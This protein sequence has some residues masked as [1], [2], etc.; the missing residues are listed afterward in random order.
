MTSSDATSD[1]RQAPLF[2]YMHREHA[3]RL[4]REGVLRIGTLHE[5]RNVERHGTHVGDAEEGSKGAR[6]TVPHL[7]ARSSVDLPEFVR[8]RIKIGSGATVEMVNPTFIVS[9]D[10]PD[11]FIFSCSSSFDPDAMREMGY[12]ACV[13]VSNP[14][15]FLHAV[16]HSMRHRGNFEGLFSCVYTERFTQPGQTHPA[17]PA[18]LKAP[19]YAPQREQRAIWRPKASSA[20]PVIITCRKAAQYCERVA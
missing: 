16:S 7:I 4:L 18:L 13:R 9:E 8:D 19:R 14:A 20:R 15:N 10:S 12:E 5:Y 11:F 2:K 3:A 17:H 1:R 6:L